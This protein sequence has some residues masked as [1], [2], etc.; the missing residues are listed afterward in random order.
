MFPHTLAAALATTI[1][2]T[3]AMAMPAPAPS[4]ADSSAYRTWFTTE[5]QPW[6]ESA[7]SLGSFSGVDGATIRYASFTQPG[8]SEAIV[9]SSGRTEF[10]KKYCEVALD[11][12]A[13]GYDVF[14]LDH[15]G[16]GASDRLLSDPEK[17]FV[18][19]FSDY[20]DDLDTMIGQVVVPLGHEQRYLLGHSMGG[21]IATYYAARQTGDIDG[22]VLTAPMM[23]INAAPYPEWLTRWLVSW[24]DWFGQG[25]SYAP[26]KGP[27]DPNSPFADNGVTQ[28]YG[29]WAASEGILSAEPGLALGGVTNRWLNESLTATQYIDRRADDIDIPTLIV[30]ATKDEIVLPGRQDAF[31]RRSATCTKVEI[32]GMHEI[33]MEVDD[34]RD[35]TLDVV[36]SFLDG[37]R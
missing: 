22:L 7:S 20:V 11:L 9:V 6:C 17:G 12:Y 36:L 31:C 18:D 32:E 24:L 25:E 13:A 14:L 4:D 37:L 1:L 5:L 10:W 15:R 2:S 28:S 8:A 21:A 33:L 26:G 35:A 16:Q 30:Q 27:R 3:Q 23:Q 19:E 29:R 34:V